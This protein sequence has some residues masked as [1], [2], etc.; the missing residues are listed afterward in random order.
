MQQ[1]SS[2]PYLSASTWG[3]FSQKSRYL[4]GPGKL[5][6]VFHVYLQDKHFNRFANDQTKLL[7]NENKLTGLSARNHATR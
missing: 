4:F 6:Y 2:N 1:Q 5:F 3:S 7:A